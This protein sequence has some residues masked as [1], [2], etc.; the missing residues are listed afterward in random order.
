MEHKMEETKCGVFSYRQTPKETLLQESLSSIQLQYINMIAEKLK[1]QFQTHPPEKW[2]VS[3]KN[4]IEIPEELWDSIFRNKNIALATPQDVRTFFGKRV[5][6]TFG[7]GTGQTFIY[8]E[9]PILICWKRGKIR[10][11]F[12]FNGSR[13]P[14]KFDENIKLWRYL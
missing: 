6:R 11:Y 13:D 7:D 4:P 12:H 5:V 14:D 10:C 1:K 8:L 3:M 2:P 9:P